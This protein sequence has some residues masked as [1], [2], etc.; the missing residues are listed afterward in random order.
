MKRLSFLLG[1]VILTS[2]QFSFSVEKNT[3]INTHIFNTDVASS[4]NNFKQS[5][6]SKRAGIKGA[7]Y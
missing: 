4:L 5:L 2:T 3:P 1:V 6:N 7:E